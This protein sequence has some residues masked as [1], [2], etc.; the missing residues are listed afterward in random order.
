MNFPL[1]VHLRGLRACCLTCVNGVRS[2]HW[3]DDVEAR[4][5]Q[6]RPYRHS[7]SSEWVRVLIVCLQACTT[8]RS[9]RTR[10]MDVSKSRD[11][12]RDRKAVGA[13]G[14]IRSELKG[15]LNY[16]LKRARPRSP[17]DGSPV[18]Q[19]IVVC[20]CLFLIQ[21]QGD[22]A[23]VGGRKCVINFSMTSSHSPVSSARTG[24]S[25]SS[26]WWTD[27]QCPVVM[28]LSVNYYFWTEH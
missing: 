10:L 8:S 20:G 25:R 16:L 11:V 19:A 23:I 5:G 15:A 17:Q 12:V 1:A 24:G 18:R 28:C 4:H 26:D 22:Q 14:G 3:L 6:V 27:E 7:H 2:R 9:L 21:L 13:G